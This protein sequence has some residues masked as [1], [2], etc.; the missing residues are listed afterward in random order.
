MATKAKSSGKPVATP[1]KGTATA[2]AASTK[3]TTGSKKK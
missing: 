1:A 2:A 3:K